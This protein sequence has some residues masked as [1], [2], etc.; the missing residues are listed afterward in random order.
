MNEVVARRLAALDRILAGCAPA[1]LALSGGVDSMTLAARA[2][3]WL[4]AGVRMYHATSPAV[5]AAATRRVRAA[6]ARHGWSLQVFVAGEFDDPDYRA[7]PVN[8]CFHCKTRLYAAVCRLTDATVLSGANLDDL[9]DYRPG[10]DAARDFAVRHPYVEAGIDKA[11]VRAIARHLG[12]GGLAELPAQ[13]CLSS[14]VETGIRIQGQVLAAV[15]AAERLI[16]ARLAPDVV[17]CRVRRRGVFIE[18]DDATLERLV[19]GDRRRLGRDVSALFAAAGLECAVDFAAYRTG[20]A[21][22]HPPG[23]P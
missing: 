21:F 7:N 15:D 23:A 19:P 8:R 12:L 4:G 22:L 6:A 5:P 18:L 1:A 17:R 11:C 10:L 20:S 9:G 2:H 13:P 14:R 3:A 16:G